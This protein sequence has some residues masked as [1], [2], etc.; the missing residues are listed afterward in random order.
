LTAM[1]LT[2]NAARAGEATAE[3]IHLVFDAPATCPDRQGF[4]DQV[5]ARTS[6][7]RLAHQNESA[8]TFAVTLSVE[9]DHVMG[10]LLITEVD[11]DRRA[12]QWID[13]R[14]RRARRRRGSDL[15]CG[16]D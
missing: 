12:W 13:H 15:G 4:L 14:Q 16:R 3:P 9:G 6:L 10:R 1:A 7:V 5:A 8:R 2:G 11:A